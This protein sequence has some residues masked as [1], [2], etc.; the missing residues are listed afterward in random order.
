MSP[1]LASVGGPESHGAKTTEKA[2]STGAGYACFKLK[3]ILLPQSAECWDSMQ[4]PLHLA[5]VHTELF[6][7]RLSS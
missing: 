3:A 1:S 6:F 7:C 4:L 2:L 5:V